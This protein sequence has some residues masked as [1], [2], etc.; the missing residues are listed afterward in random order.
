MTNVKPNP[1]SLAFAKPEL[2]GEG[3]KVV[4]VEGRVFLGG[5]R[6]VWYVSGSPVR[7]RKGVEDQSRI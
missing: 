4:P 6:S 2:R 5:E 1:S 7:F 3:F